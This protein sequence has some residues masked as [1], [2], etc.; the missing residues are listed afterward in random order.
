MALL[1]WIEDENLLSAVSHLLVTAEKAK[2]SAEKELGKNVIDPFSAIFEISGFQID[3]DTWLKSETTRQAQKTL[4]N[5]IGDFHQKILG[6]VKDWE[7]KTTGNVIDLV[8]HK[9]KILA[10]IKNKHNT[11]SGGKLSDLYYSLEK[12]VM[13]K[14]SIYKAYGAYYV[15]I[16]PKKKERYNREFTPSDKEKGEK[17]PV[18]KK[19]REIDGASFYDLVTNH[20]D[21]LESLF[22]I[23]PH[24]ISVCSKGVFEIKDPKKLKSLFSIAFE[25]A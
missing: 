18:N 24:A 2:V 5:H 13:P 22:D 10:E 9:H 4:Q 11:I 21:A 6:S 20:K 23:L 16:I 17:C 14:M 1:P 7:N 3:H 8:S 19:I 12:A 15:A 25:K